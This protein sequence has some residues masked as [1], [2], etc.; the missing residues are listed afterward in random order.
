MVL[1]LFTSTYRVS[2]STILVTTPSTQPADPRHSTS[3]PEYALSRSLRSVSELLRLPRV[4]SILSNVVVGL[5]GSL[6]LPRVFSTNCHSLLPSGIL[7]QVRSSSPLSTSDGVRSLIS[8]DAFARTRLSAVFDSIDLSSSIT[9][10][11]PDSITAC[12]GSLIVAD[13][14]KG[15]IS[16]LPI[17]TS[18]A[19]GLYSSIHSLAMSL[20]IGL[21]STS[22]TKMLSPGVTYEVS[23]SLTN[24]IL[25]SPSIASKGR[26][27]SFSVSLSVTLLSTRSIMSLAVILDTAFWPTTE[28]MLPPPPTRESSNSAN[29]VSRFINIIYSLSRKKRIGKY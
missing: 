2:P 18:T 19:V 10:V 3:D 17:L 5:S 26:G 28:G 15:L 1:L 6:R 22:F 27:D 14:N 7:C 29:A 8:P 23:A 24:G 16:K 11:S 20:P 21:S 9:Y 4:F 12:D 25:L 13:V